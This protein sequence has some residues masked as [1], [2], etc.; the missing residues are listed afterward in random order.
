V[1]EAVDQYGCTCYG[2]ISLNKTKSATIPGEKPLTNDGQLATFKL[3]P[4][5]TNGQVHWQAGEGFPID[6]AKLKVYSA[7]G[8]IVLERN[9]PGNTGSKSVQSIDLSAQT[10]GVYL[11]EISGNGYYKIEKVIVRTN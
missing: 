2:Q 10:H 5:I 8:Q 3:Y 11:V 9:Y 6:G 1:V 7:S 4:T